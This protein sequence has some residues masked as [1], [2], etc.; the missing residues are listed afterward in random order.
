[1]VLVIIKP[2]KQEGIG[3]CPGHSKPIEPLRNTT[4]L[5]VREEELS[6]HCSS[7]MIMTGNVRNFFGALV[8]SLHNIIAARLQMCLRLL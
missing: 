3:F 5:T 4:Y 6:W 8:P 7:A 2:P 1:M